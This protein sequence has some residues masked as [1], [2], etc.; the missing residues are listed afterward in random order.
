MPTAAPVDAAAMETPAPRFSFF[1]RGMDSR[2]VLL[3][4]PPILPVVA[5][6]RPILTAA[7][8]VVVVLASSF[9]PT[10]FCNF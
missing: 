4:P 5:L 6:F 8:A 1:L 10:V 9:P 7:A 3:L 2:F